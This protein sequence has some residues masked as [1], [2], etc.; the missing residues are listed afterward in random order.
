MQV[1]TLSAGKFFSWSA[2]DLSKY[3]PT[4]NSIVNSAALHG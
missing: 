4:E 1:T 2:A 3:L